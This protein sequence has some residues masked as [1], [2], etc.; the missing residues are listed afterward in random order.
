MG[1]NVIPKRLERLEQELAANRHPKLIFCWTR[2]LADRISKV[3]P[4]YTMGSI[5]GMTGAAD[6]D[7]LEA[8]VRENPIESARLDRLL[9]GIPE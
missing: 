6:D 2:S 4:G 5:A 3:L 9:A 7:Q 8:M 1:A